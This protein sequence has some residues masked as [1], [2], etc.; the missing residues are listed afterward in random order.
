MLLLRLAHVSLLA[1]IRG[2]DGGV[3]ERSEGGKHEC[4]GRRTVDRGGDNVVVIFPAVDLSLCVLNASPI[5]VHRIVTKRS[6]LFCRIANHI[7]RRVDARVHV[8]GVKSTVHV[9]VKWRVIPRSIHVGNWNFWWNGGAGRRC[10]CWRKRHRGGH[11]G[12]RHRGHRGGGRHHR[13][14][15]RRHRGR[16]I[17]HLK[18][19]HWCLT[20]T[21]ALYGRRLHPRWIGKRQG[22]YSRRWCWIV[23]LKWQNRH[24]CG[25]PRHVSTMRHLTDGVLRNRSNL[26]GGGGFRAHQRPHGV[27]CG[28]R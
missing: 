27:E 2:L 22:R 9:L 18:L 20:S 15:G 24:R 6:A 7:E 21:T 14:H 17:V 25:R 8:M 28:K 12:R 5:G 3:N 19:K 16:N 26:S 4:V 11:R 13:H 23:Q 10:C 1:W